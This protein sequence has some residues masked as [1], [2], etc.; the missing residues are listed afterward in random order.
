MSGACSTHREMRSAYKIF[1]RKPE[2]KGPLR[3]L[4]YWWEDN[5]KMDVREISG[6]VWI[7]FIWLRIACEHLRVK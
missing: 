6:R 5:I 7:A 1:L 3:R 4:R 2:V